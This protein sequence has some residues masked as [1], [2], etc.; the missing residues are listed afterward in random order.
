MF[1]SFVLYREMRL[2][3]TP[4][5][6]YQHRE[7][8][9]TSNRRK[10]SKR[11]ISKRQ[12]RSGEPVNTRQQSARGRAAL[13]AR[14]W[15]RRAG[16]GCGFALLDPAIAGASEARSEGV[17]DLEVRSPPSAARDRTRREPGEPAGTDAPGLPLKARRSARH[18]VQIVVRRPQPR[19]VLLDA[20]VERNT[21]Y[22]RQAGAHGRGR[23]NSVGGGSRVF[24]DTSRAAIRGR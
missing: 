24:A 19:S 18:P 15:A 13:G 12:T 3:N 4:L 8:N 22:Q 9:Q 10:P 14:R 21:K 5:G 11:K 17:S 16:A 7:A 20:D 1:L 23:K 2:L 6:R